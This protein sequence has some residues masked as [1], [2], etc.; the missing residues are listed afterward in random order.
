MF[1]LYDFQLGQ[2]EAVCPAGSEPNETPGLAGCR[3][4]PGNIE[5][6]EA[7]SHKLLRCTSICLPHERYDVVQEKCVAGSPSALTQQ[8]STSGRG[9]GLLIGA[10]LLL[11]F[12]ASILAASP[13]LQQSLGIA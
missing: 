8:T 2:V 1:D 9:R 4:L 5:V 10:L 13:E 12:G 7:G 3:C 6:R 11:A